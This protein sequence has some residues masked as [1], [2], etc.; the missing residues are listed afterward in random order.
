MTIDDAQEVAELCALA[1]C[2]ERTA[3]YLSARTMP[4]KV[5][6]QLL[7]ARADSPE[8]SSRIV[9]DATHPTPQSLNENPLVMAAR[10]RAGK[11]N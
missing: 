6:S 8:I 11:E 7:N 10:A 4:T 1:G 9:P 2:P 3:A 5:R